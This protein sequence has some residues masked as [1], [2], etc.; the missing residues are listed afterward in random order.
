[1]T[2]NV[3]RALIVCILSVDGEEWE[4]VAGKMDPDT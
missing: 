2:G 1:V 3:E 4:S